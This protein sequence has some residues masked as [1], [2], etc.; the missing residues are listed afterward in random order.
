VLEHDDVAGLL[1]AEGVAAR[2]HL[3]QHVPVPHRRLH[4]ADA[5]SLHGLD[6][7]QVAHHGG[8]ERVVGQSA[9]LAQRQREDRHDL[10]AVDLLALRVHGQAAVGVAVEGDPHVGAPQADGLLQLGHVGGAVAVVDVQPVGLA[11]DDVHGRP[12]APE[13][14]RADHRGRAVRTVDDHAQPVQTSRDRGQQ[15]LDVELRTAREGADPADPRTGRTV[16]PATQTLGDAVLDLVGELVPA[17]R[18]ELQTV[19]RHRVV[20]GRQHGTHLGVQPLGEVGDRRRGEDTRV[21]HVHARR[22]QAGHHRGGEEL[23]RGARVTAHDRRRAVAAE[24][25]LA[26]QLVRDRD[27][28]VQCQLGGDVLVGQPAHP[29]GAE[30]SCHYSALASFLRPAARQ[31]GLTEYA[32]PARPPRRRDRQRL[33]KRRS[34]AGQGSVQVAQEH[35]SGRSPAATLT[36]A[37]RR[38]GAHVMSTKE[39]TDAPHPS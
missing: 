22:R 6:Q 26:A 10:V 12:G 28:Q 27:R 14:L 1:P 7:A 30:Q 25:P 2:P 33:P 4:D 24:R 29:V 39:L 8:D 17:A 36:E 37:P 3:L 15:V 19:V 35:W 9:L 18:E 38:G 11:A 23:P 21:E 16:P 13:D 34:G 20:R 31:V 32:A 5:L